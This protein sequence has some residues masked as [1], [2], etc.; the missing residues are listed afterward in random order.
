ML[1]FHEKIRG[2]SIVLL[3]GILSTGCGDTPQPALDIKE[4]EIV[5]YKLTEQLLPDPQAVL[6]EEIWEDPTWRI[7]EEE[8]FIIDGCWY[9]HSR[10]YINGHGAVGS[11]VQVLDPP[12]DQWENY[13]ISYMRLK[14][15][16]GGWVENVA[17]V[18]E[19]GMLLELAFP[20]QDKYQL[21]YYRWD[22]T[23]EPVMELPESLNGA[24]WYRSGEELF[25][26]S[27]ESRTLAAFDQTYQEQYCRNL[28]GKVMGLLEDPADDTFYWYGFEL[29]ELVLWDGASGQVSYKLTDQINPYGDF[30]LAYSPFGELLLANTE[31]V[32]R[33]EEEHQELRELFSFMDMEYPIDTLYGCS[34]R[35]DGTPLFFVEYEGEK[36]LLAAEV[37]DPAEVS[38][39]QEITLALSMDCYDVRQI[40]V[41][42]NRQSEE[43][44]LTVIAPDEGEDREDYCRRIQ[45]EIAAGGGPDLLGNGLLN[46]REAAA[47]GYLEPLDW[48][49]EDMSPFLESAFLTGQIDGVLYGIPYTTH[50]AF[51]T[52]SRQITEADSWTLEEMM[53]AVRNSPA[54][55][56][57]YGRSGVGIV[58]Y[59]GLYDEE[60]KAFIDW[61]EGESH[62]TENPFLEL[63]AFAREYA[64]N[65][66][67]TDSELM[68]RLR[69]GTIA[70][71]DLYI[72]EPNDMN[73]M[74]A[75]FNGEEVL[76]GYPRVSGNGI[77]MIARNLYMN[78][79]SVNKE[80]AAEFLRY[81][82]TEEGQK[83]QVTDV[84][85]PYMSVRR[86]LNAEFIENFQK[87]VQDPPAQYQ[88]GGYFWEET[89]LDEEQISQYWWLLDNARSG[90]FR[91]DELWSMVEEELEPYFSGDRSAEEAAAVLDSRVQLY[92]DERK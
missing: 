20:N 61:E 74:K 91:A 18:E 35:E 86:D 32:W 24:F 15:D 83:R 70:G 1:I 80:G 36:H 37:R 82:L 60:N 58:M 67:Y 77:Y 13:G 54:E 48:I 23:W 17:G 30:C 69:D 39:K 26:A 9:L 27:G 92:L 11:C 59:Y 10:F 87:N 38:E 49:V 28:S 42:F 79:N 16:I 25:A 55:I 31:R 2:I 63:M 50:P 78:C 40:A 3:F 41:G 68:N 44:H 52:V 8:S 90:S 19:E 46:E 43:Y 7:Q 14:E 29:E 57:E 88:T 64:D 5:S 6:T 4:N 76:I 71:V 21:G 12:Y 56:L 53:E 33:Y 75:C 45:L 89:A 51:L 66:Q 85:S 84:R 65:G 72:M 62:L 47:G 34:F 22:G 73:K 81:M